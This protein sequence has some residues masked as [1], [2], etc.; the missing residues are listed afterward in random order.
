MS[1]KDMFDAP[2]YRDIRL[3]DMLA[4]VDRELKMRQRVYPR[5]VDQGKLD[6]VTADRQLLTMAAIRERLV[7]ETS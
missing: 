2:N 7:N 5:L 4:E 6:P 3:K 1:G